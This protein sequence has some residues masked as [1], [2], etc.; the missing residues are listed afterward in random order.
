MNSPIS[1]IDNSHAK[2]ETFTGREWV[3]QK[4]YEWLSEARGSRYFLLTGKPGSGKTAIAA[5]LT[6]FSQ[7]ET[8]L[9]S[10][11]APG[12]LSAIHTCSARDSTSVDPKNFARS[13]AL[14][15][16]KK[17][18][19]FANALNNV[20]EKPINI[21]V[22]F[23]IQKAENTLIQGVRIDNLSVAGLSGQEFFN[24]AV[25][26]PLEALYNDEVNFPITILVDSLDEALTHSGVDT[27]VDLL[28]KL[29]SQIKIRW[30]L[31]SRQEPRVENA[32]VEGAD[33]LF[34]S[35]P[36]FS[37]NNRQDIRDYIEKRL[38][39]EDSL[40]TQMSG[41]NQTQRA[42][43]IAQLTDKSD[44]NFQ[45]ISF[46]L[47]AVAKDDKR[48]LFDLEGLPEGLDG[49]YYDSLQRVVSLGKKDWREVYAP[50]L[51]IL[52]VAQEALTESQIQAFTNRTERTVCDCLNDLWQ[53]LVPD[54][55]PLNSDQEEGESQYRLYHQSIVDFLRKRQLKLD[56]NTRPCHNLYYLPAQEFHQNVV[57][58]YT[59]NCE[60]PWQT[61]SVEEGYFWHYFPY[62]LREAELHEAKQRSSLKKLLLNFDWLQAKLNATDVIQLIADYGLL[63]EDKNLWLVQR[64]IQLSTSVLVKDK[65]ELAGQLLGRLLGFEDENTEIRAL[66]EQV[67][68][69]NAKPWLQPIRPNLTPP[70]RG[71]LH[72]L[73]GHTDY[74][75]AVAVIPNTHQAIS[76]S[77]DGTLKIWNLE[78]GECQ[79]T[80]G[81]HQSWEGVVVSANGRHAI[82]IAK[83][84]TS[85][86]LKNAAT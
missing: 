57:D 47:D 85:L 22:D 76:A 81:E 55:M 11:F 49:L 13:V 8:P 53:F 52:S 65:A 74:V 34:L 12:F 73:S 19:P 23:H 43:K 45:Y 64:A 21:N 84:Q 42:D 61:L 24:R 66:L 68:Q 63:P 15:L 86:S 80:L 38:T 18:Q 37:Q 10:N 46:F 32:L 51:G 5:R 62:H 78:T 59:N 58:H 27:I 28:S 48:S 35:A 31:T 20:G 29:P 6:Q 70:S 17:F 40:T 33:G 50:V 7:N 39:Q 16:A 26:E 71:L 72:I 41:L 3:F 82:S 83:D 25:L 75:K 9:H 60:Q 77:H 79:R 4:I 69:H 44:G 36:E 67:K 14:R 2:L 56:N 30:I 54:E 1:Q